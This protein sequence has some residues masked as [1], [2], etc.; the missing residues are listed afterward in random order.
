M[1]ETE[2]QAARI[3]RLC[4]IE[5]LARW[6]GVSTTSVYRWDHAKEKGGSGGLIPV[7]YHQ[8][9][10]T[11]A[12]AEGIVLTPDDFFPAAARPKAEPVAGSGE[13]AA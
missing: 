6:T 3:I 8:P 12:T 10:L 5:N 4:G 7:T 1:T 11:G 2:T 13:A 9:I